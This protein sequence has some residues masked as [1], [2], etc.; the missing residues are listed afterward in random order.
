MAV[1]ACGEEFSDRR[2]AIGYNSCLSC[3]S[4]AA[5]EETLRKMACIVPQGPKQGMTFVADTRR[6]VKNIH[7]QERA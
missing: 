3:G 7:K 6:Q 5:K 4:Q 1:C 2:K